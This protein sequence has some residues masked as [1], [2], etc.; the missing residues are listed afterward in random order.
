MRHHLE[1]GHG[2][3][4]EVSTQALWWPPSK[5]AGVYLAPYLDELPALEPERAPEVPLAVEPTS[6]ATSRV[7]I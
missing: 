6:E 1:G 3:D 4:A 5:I 7:W 2:E